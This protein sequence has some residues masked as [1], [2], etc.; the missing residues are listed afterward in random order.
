MSNTQELA[1]DIAKKLDILIRAEV[2]KKTDE[3]QLHRSNFEMLK[4]HIEDIHSEASAL[5]EDMKTNGFTAG[6]LEAEGYLR[7]A[8]TLLNVLK[9]LKND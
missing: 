9:D 6:T 5:Y 2:S 1:E 4:F 3:F 8:T 7:C